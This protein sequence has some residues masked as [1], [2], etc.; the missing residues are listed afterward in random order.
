MRR[1]GVSRRHLFETV[2]RP[3][4]ADLPDADY[5]FAEW[6]LARVSL[7]H[8]VEVCG[9]FYSVPH[10]LIHAQVDPTCSS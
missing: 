4:L 3:A 6:G 8:H 9:Y 5:E 7:D 2:E 10:N 1:L